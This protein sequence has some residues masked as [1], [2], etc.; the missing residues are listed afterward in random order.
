MTDEQIENWR[1]IIFQILE[2]KVKGAGIYALV[3]PKEE[4]IKFRD[5]IQSELIPKLEEE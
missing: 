5:K 1:K 2:E 4:I 3:M